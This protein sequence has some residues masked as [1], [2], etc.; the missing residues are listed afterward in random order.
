MGKHLLII[1]IGGFLGSVSRY[2]TS[3]MVSKSWPSITILG[4]F[5]AN[6]LGCFLLGIIYGLYLKYD[7]F[8]NGW[9]L[10]LA[11]GFCGGYTTFSSFAFEN[12]E[13]LQ[14]GN[15]KMF[16]TYTLTSLILGIVAVFGGL[17]LIK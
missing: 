16:I 14:S 11:T 9:R 13:M 4:T 1:G 8:N 15:Y 2:L 6:V 3:V 5:A 7:G 10:F 12:V 17:L